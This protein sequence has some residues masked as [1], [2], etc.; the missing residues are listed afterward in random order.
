M[1]PIAITI[2]LS[3]SLGLLIAQEA[4]TFLLQYPISKGDTIIYKRIIQLY[5]SNNLY[6]VK[7]YFDNGQIQMDAY[8]SSFKSK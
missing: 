8:Y 1:K 6:H 7:D 2:L 3:F 5:K 4:D